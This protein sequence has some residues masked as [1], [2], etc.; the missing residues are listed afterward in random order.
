MKQKPWVAVLLCLLLGGCEFKT[1]DDLLQAPQPSKSYE[2]LQNQLETQLESGASYAAPLKGDNRSTVQLMDLNGDGEDEAIACFRR[3]NELEVIIYRKENDA[4]VQVG[5]VLGMGTNIDHIAYPTLGA[6]GTLGVLVAWQ[7][8]TEAGTALSV[9]DYENDAINLLLEKEYT[10]YVLSDLDSNGAQELAVFNLDGTS[11]KYAELYD[12][13]ATTTQMVCVGEASMS[14]DAQSVRGVS[15]GLIA[16]NQ[17]AI[18]VEERTSSGVGQQT[19]IFVYA[20]GTGL[21]NL[22]LDSEESNAQSTYRVVSVDAADVN[23]DGQT[24]VPRAVLMPG[25][26]EGAGDALYMLDWYLY[27]STENPVRVQTTFRNSNEY[28]SLLLPESWYGEVQ[29]VKNLNGTTASTSFW[30]LEGEE[31]TLLLEIFYF[32]G[33]L[34]SYYASQEGMIALGSSEY[35]TY[36]ARIPDSGVGHA[37]EISAETVQMSFSVITTAWNS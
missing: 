4:Y 16:N 29:A 8:A 23:Y 17:P 12:Y 21:R 30:A 31:R 18:F 11:R 5:S 6:D 13:D 1:G 26:S 2:S 24:E 37:L 7:L 25:Y 9:A 10:T 20:E 19:D 14:P 36:A 3:D 33:D 22:A 32:T 15:T 28:W 34:R 27:S 35:A